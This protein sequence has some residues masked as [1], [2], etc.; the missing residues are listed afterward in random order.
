MA[1]I[2][3]VI[4]EILDDLE[5]MEEI[6]LKTPAPSGEGESGPVNGKPASPTFLVA[7]VAASGTSDALTLRMLEQILAP[8]SCTLVNI[9]GT[10]SPM[11]LA[12]RVAEVSPAMIILP[13]L[14]P[15][16]LA[17]AGMLKSSRFRR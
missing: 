5:G 13:H 3:R 10:G 15:E 12:D 7:G 6:S 9:E 17:Q 2:R 1:F 14:P 8:S 4:G 11:Q 16:A